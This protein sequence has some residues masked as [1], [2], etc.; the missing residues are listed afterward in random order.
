MGAFHSAWAKEIQVRLKLHT[1]KTCPHFNHVALAFT[2][3]RRL[4][5]VLR[6]GLGSGAEAV[7][8][9][10]FHSAWAKEIQV[11]SKLHTIKTCP[12][13]NHVALTFTGIRRLNVVWR[14]SRGSGA[15]AV[16]HGGLP[17]SLGEE[18]P[19][20]VKASHHPKVPTLQ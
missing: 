2:G 13:F 5:V 8:H 11:R 1:I 19:G 17:L 12:R 20:K 4:N 3:I 16:Q 6:P 7:Q 15:E 14:H 18:N 9:G 10:A